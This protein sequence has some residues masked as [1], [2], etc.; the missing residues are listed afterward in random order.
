MST[1]TKLWNEFVAGVTFAEFPFITFL[2]S[3]LAF[4]SLLSIQVLFA[5]TLVIGANSTQVTFASSFGIFLVV[6]GVISL[7]A[8]ILL[9]YVVRD[10]YRRIKW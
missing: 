5:V 4:I 6:S 2:L 9:F 1:R 8:T 3:L 7:A 10:Q